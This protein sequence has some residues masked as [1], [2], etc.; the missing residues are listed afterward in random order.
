MYGKNTYGLEKYAAKQSGSEGEEE[1]FVDL[2]CYA[3]PLFTELIEMS[4]IYKSQGG[5]IGVLQY[6]TEELIK[7][8]YVATAEWGLTNWEKDFGVDT[9]YALSYEQ[10]REI[11]YAKIRGQGTTTR[12]MLIDA[13]TAFSGG[14]VDVIEN[15]KEYQFTVRFI[16]IKGIPRN[17]NAFIDMLEEIKPA[18]LSYKFEY[19][20]TVWGEML[21][22]TWGEL[23]YTWD[24]LRILKEDE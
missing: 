14:D 5:E 9:N 21:K 23:N 16:G 4:E 22:Y 18:H 2:S 17:M 8:L 6:D 1:H 13:A 20:Y 3:P 12:D 15:N 7:Q 11:L 10:R 19:R 24:E